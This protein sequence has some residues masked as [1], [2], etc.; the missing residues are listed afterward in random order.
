MNISSIVIITVITI[1]IIMFLYLSI[2]NKGLRQ[3]AIQLIVEAEKVFEY[4]KSS[5]KFNYV[6]E[7]FYSRLPTLL[8]II[9]TKDNVEVF[10]Q[11][12]FDEIK[13]A[14]DYQNREVK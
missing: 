2:K 10:I 12:V 13:I 8:K 9:V 6:F 4:E 1:I 14:L 7:Q 5:Q 11:K 3:V